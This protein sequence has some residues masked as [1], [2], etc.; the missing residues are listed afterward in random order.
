MVGTQNRSLIGDSVT[1]QIDAGKAAHGGNLDQGLFHLWIA[2]HIPLLLQ[3]DPQH[4]RQWVRR[5]VCLLAALGV[6]GL[7]Q[8]DQRLL[9][10]YHLHL[11][12]KLLAFGLLLGRSQLVVRKGKLLAAHHPC[13]NPQSQEQCYA[14]GQNFPE[15]H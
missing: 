13:P 2:E 12:E 8:C 6:V 7:D 3:V 11:R 10:H 15:T 14:D 9:G 4:G 1:D 5:P